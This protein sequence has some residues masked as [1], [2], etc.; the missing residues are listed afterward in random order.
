MD[1]LNLSAPNSSLQRLLCNLL[2]N[3]VIFHMNSQGES[4]IMVF[5]V[6]ITHCLHPECCLPHLNVPWY[7]Y[8]I[9]HF[10]SSWELILPPPIL[11]P[12]SYVPLQNPIWELILL[13]FPEVFS[14]PNFFLLYQY[15]KL[16]DACSLEEK[17]WP[18]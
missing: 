15:M 9:S 14:A 12:H 10:L 1:G 4:T 13:I 6:L 16:T 2:K 3:G 11:L 8:L 5:N 18:T 17:L 7:D